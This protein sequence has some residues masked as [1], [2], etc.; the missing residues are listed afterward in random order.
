MLYARDRVLQEAGSGVLAI[1][2]DSAGRYYLL[3]TPP[4]VILVYDSE[5]KQ[6]GQIPNASSSPDSITY[7]LDLAIDP[8]GHVLVAD[9]GANAV[10]IFSSNGLLITK[11]PVFAPVSIAVLSGGEFVVATLRSQTPLQ[12]MDEQGKLIRKFTVTRGADVDEKSTTQALADP[13]KVAEDPE[14]NVFL[15]SAW[16]ADPSIRKYDRYGSVSYESPIALGPGSDPGPANDRVQFALNFMHMGLSDQFNGWVTVGSSGQV[17]FGTNMGMGMREMMGGA[18]GGPPSQGAAG[19]SMSG[20][21]P[22]G[23]MPGAGGAPGGI[24]AMGAL[25][26]MGG[27]GGSL[28][29]GPGGMD[30]ASVSGQGSLKDGK[31]HFRLGLGP[32]APPRMGSGTG[33]MPGTSVPS[34][35]GSG[36]SDVPDSQF[37]L[38][39]AT[40]PSGNLLSLDLTDPSTT[41]NFLQFASGDSSA[42]ENVLEFG[43]RDTPDSSVSDSASGTDLSGGM[44]SEYGMMLGGMGFAPIGG[45]VGGMM[46]L[47]GAQ[48]NKSQGV[49]SSGSLGPPGAGQ[50]PPGGFGSSG[51][52][53]TSRFRPPGNFGPSMVNLT[54]SVRLNL[55]RPHAVQEERLAITAVGVDPS[56]DET[57]VAIGNALVHMDKTGTVLDTFYMATAE[58]AKLR[59]SAILVESNRLIIATE[60]QGIFEF[61][62]PDKVL[63]AQDRAT[64]GNP[65]PALA[66]H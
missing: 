46:P 41:Q 16:P 29:M 22:G 8:G 19:G 36:A 61:S 11:I 17:N 35:A 33:P 49:P 34:G 54:A 27:M 60:S 14:G 66:D 59:A 43:S 32:N 47:V 13:G 25:G 56:S 62:R 10:E 15:A 52:G 50:G 28:G 26:G 21:M 20:G 37:S 39:A 44:L 7:A 31:F 63:S 12:M 51:P 3:A 57:W 53:T 23:M 58:G 6:V 5:G 2:R 48:A 65:G 38:L 40:D 1:K 64:S 45:A 55:D 24:R 18:M 30:L 4:K 42:G 9:R